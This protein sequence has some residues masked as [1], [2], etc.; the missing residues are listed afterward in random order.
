MGSVLSWCLDMSEIF[1]KNNENQTLAVKGAMS[2]QVHAQANENKLENVN[3]LF[4]V[5]SDILETCFIC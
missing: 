1:L 2:P 3:Q 4:Q 5:L